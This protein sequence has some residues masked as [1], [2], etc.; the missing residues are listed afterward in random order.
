MAPQGLQNPSFP[1]QL[2]LVD[3]HSSTHPGL[4]FVRLILLE[5]SPDSGRDHYSPAHSRSPTQQRRGRSWQG[6]G[7]PCPMTPANWGLPRRNACPPACGHWPS[8]FLCLECPSSSLCFQ[9][10]SLFHLFQAA[11][12]GPS[13]LPSACAACSLPLLIRV[14]PVQASWSCALPTLGQ[15]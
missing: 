14:W 3:Y 8:A 7:C 2:R 15:P 6:C 1:L 10:P 13:S 9:R 4:C 11:L 12:L 5:C